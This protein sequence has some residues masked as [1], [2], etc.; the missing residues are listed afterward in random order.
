MQTPLTPN[1]V[2]DQFEQLGNTFTD[3]AEQHGYTANEVYRVLNGQ[4]KAKYGKAHEIAVKLGLKLSPEQVANRRG[5]IG[6]RRDEAHER[7]AA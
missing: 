1:Q 2:K 5:E 7:R 4:A 6:E 3:W